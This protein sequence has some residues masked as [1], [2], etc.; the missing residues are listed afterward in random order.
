MGLRKMTSLTRNR[1]ESS[2]HRRN[3]GQTRGRW[4]NI[5]LS[6]K[7]RAREK[8][9][10]RE[11]LRQRESFKCPES[12]GPSYLIQRLWRVLCGGGGNS[13]SRTVATHRSSSVHSLLL[14]LSLSGPPPTLPLTLLPEFCSNSQSDHLPPAPALG[15]GG[16]IP[17]CHVWRQWWWES[18][19]APLRFPL[20]QWND[21][22]QTSSLLSNTKHNSAIVLIPNGRLPSAPGWQTCQSLSNLPDCVSLYLSEFPSDLLGYISSASLVFASCTESGTFT[23]RVHLGLTQVEH[24]LPT[25]L[26]KGRSWFLLFT[27]LSSCQ[28]IASLRLA[29]LQDVQ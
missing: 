5:G 2:G 14:F 10:G 27:S 19:G 8:E 15:R 7:H 1:Q 12:S 26:A 28:T 3:R 18:T 17:L 6:A 16:E 23:G 13:W 24:F 29:F 22:V 25:W 20:C 11:E 4:E 9:K 21:Q